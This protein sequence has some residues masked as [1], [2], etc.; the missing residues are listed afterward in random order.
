MK[1]K[2]LQMGSVGFE[3]SSVTSTARGGCPGQRTDDPPSV[4]RSSSRWS[5]ETMMDLQSYGLME[6][7]YGIREEGIF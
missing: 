5:G 3:T 1:M 4:S 7:R 6:E 2:S